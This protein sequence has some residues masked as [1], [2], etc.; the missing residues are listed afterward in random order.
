M[1][2]KCASP[3]HDEVVERFAAYRSD[4]PLNAALLPGRARC[5]EVIS[6]PHCTNA[7]EVRWTECAVAVANQMM[8]R[9]VPGKGI[10]HLSR[11]LLGGWVARHV[12]GHQSPSGVAKDD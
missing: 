1:L 6:D 11:D 5:C 7:S 4:E 10:G 2:R 9:F 12:D 3:N 8:R